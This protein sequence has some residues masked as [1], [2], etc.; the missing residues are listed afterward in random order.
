[1]ELVVVPQ[2]LLIQEI[3]AF[4]AKMSIAKHVQEIISA[5][6]ALITTIYPVT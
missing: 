1:V 4:I 3:F 5:R 2:L 6:N